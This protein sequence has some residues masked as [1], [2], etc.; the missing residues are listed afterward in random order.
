MECKTLRGAECWGLPSPLF[1]GRER[2]RGTCSWPA[3]AREPQ[4]L[5]HARH[6]S[7]SFPVNTP[8]KGSCGVAARAQ[9]PTLSQA[10]HLAYCSAAT[11]FKVLVVEQGTLHFRLHWNPRKLS[12]WSCPPDMHITAL[13]LAESF[14]GVLDPSRR[15]ALQSPKPLIHAL[16]PAGTPGTTLCQLLGARTRC[17]SSTRHHCRSPRLVSVSSNRA[18]TASLSLLPAPWVPEQGIL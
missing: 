4:N 17:G 1:F 2:G 8:N 15:S 6:C 5:S 3:W 14:H 16:R 18:L 7:R 11:V 10:P 9:G 12:V 13:Q